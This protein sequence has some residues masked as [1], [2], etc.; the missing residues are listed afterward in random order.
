MK[1]IYLLSILAF[2]FIS[3]EMNDDFSSNLISDSF[4]EN[5]GDQVS[6]DFMGE[7]VDENNNP[8]QNV[9]VSIGNLSA[10]TDANG[11]FIIKNAPVLEKFAYIKTEKLGFISGSRSLAPTS[12]MNLV[13]IMMISNT[14]IATI[15]SGV[16][17]EV[18]LPNGTKVNFDGNFKDI[19][20]NTYSGVVNVSMYHLESSNENLSSLMPGMLIAKSN[21]DN[22]PKV[23]ETFGM[24]NVELTGASGQKLQIAT[25]HVA[26]VSMKIDDNQLS[27][28]PSTIPLWHF[29]EV[30]GYWK[31]DG[32]ATKQGNYYVGNVSHFSWWNCDQFLASAFLNLSIKDNSNNPL[33]YS[34]V[35]I[36]RANNS[37][38]L[39][40]LTDVNG[41]TR[42]FVPAN[43]NLNAVIIDACENLIYLPIGNLS[44]NSTNTINLIYTPSGN[45]NLVTVEGNLKDCNANNVTNGY[46]M[47]SYGNN[48]RRYTP[49][50]VSGNF[51][52]NSMYCLPNINYT[53]TGFDFSSL[54][55]TN[56][57]NYIYPLN[58]NLVNV[59][60]LMTCNSISE[61]ISYQIDNDPTIY[62]LSNIDVS[63]TPNGLSISTFN[64]PV[65]NGILIW[66]NSNII[67][68]QSN[69][70]IEGSDVGLIDQS[71]TSISFTLN[72]FGNVGD[73]VDISFYGS[74][75]SIIDNQTHTITGIAHVIRDN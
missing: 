26:Q 48:H 33:S 66:C 14:P 43:E 31:E 58:T 49:T 60:N 24:L 68:N 34:F 52:I 10:N 50:D 25:N 36:Q 64:N 69:F 7:V 53:L 39:S 47:L 72:S 29:D 12:G 55:T 59:G 65:Q 13:K 44:A 45:A 23:L 19:N 17:S 16:A 54:Q 3:C 75:I 32:F 27:T 42:G 62:H 18:T 67:G 57:I 38:S 11:V 4:T 35:R 2:V 6:R 21:D 70:G 22:L 40:Q 41:F 46:V 37:I 61:F 74:Y 73:F 9:L 15:N 51:S 28:S 1:K 5:F 71:S 20:G 56:Q 30:L 8:I 63:Y